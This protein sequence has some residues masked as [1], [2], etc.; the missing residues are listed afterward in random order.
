MLNKRT[1]THLDKSEVGAVSILTMYLG[2]WGFWI[3]LV[4]IFRIY[5]SHLS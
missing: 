3:S 2:R 4:I 5:A 1:G